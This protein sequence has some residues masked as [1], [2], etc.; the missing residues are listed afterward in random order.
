MANAD[1]FGAAGS[2]II[3]LL[4]VY[5]SSILLYFGAE[6]TKSYAL[7]QG[8]GIQANKYSILVQYKEIEIDR[9]IDNQE[10]KK[11]NE[12]KTKSISE[13]DMKLS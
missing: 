1:I 11:I 6:F 7:N 4:W 5:Y 10:L 13:D 2:I 9:P 12:E 8:Q 3:L